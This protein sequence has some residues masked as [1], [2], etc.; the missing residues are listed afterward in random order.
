[1]T[2]SSAA[3]TNV[4]PIQRPACTR[5]AATCPTRAHRRL[6]NTLSSGGSDFNGDLGFMH[7]VESDESA[8]APLWVRRHDE[9][10]AAP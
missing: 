10:D 8:T 3:L 6:G 5:A 7:T 2:S 4:S 1:V 9:Y